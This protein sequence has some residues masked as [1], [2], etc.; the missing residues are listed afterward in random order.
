MQNIK[1]I[2]S[3]IIALLVLSAIIG[4]AFL[5]FIALFGL[6]VII[7]V[8]I[9]IQNLLRSNK[10][11]EFD[12]QNLENTDFSATKITIIEGEVIKDNN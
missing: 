5:G 6:A 3:I 9:Y 7:A 1:N 4:V 2:I 11:E 10:D 8:A 12:V